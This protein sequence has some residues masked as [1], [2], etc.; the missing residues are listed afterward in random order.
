M[1]QEE[2]QEFK[3]EATDLLNE[4]ENSLLLVEKG[5]DFERHYDSIFRA[6][7]SL[8]GAAGMLELTKLQDH[9]HTIENHF[10][11][12]KGV[13][14]I[15]QALVS[16]FLAA[17]DASRSLLDDKPVNFSYTLPVEDNKAKPS[18]DNVQE[19]PLKAGPS[20]ASSEPNLIF[21]ID[22]EADLVEYIGDILKKYNYPWKGF[23]DPTE[24]LAELEE[25]KPALVLTDMKMPKISG[26]EVL[27]SVKSYNSSLPVIFISGHLTKENLME[28]IALG[29]QGV[30]EKPFRESQ[31]ISLVHLSLKQTQMWRLLNR[32]IDMILF[33]FQD[34]E[35]FL[36]AANKPDILNILKH[37]MEQLLNARRELKKIKKP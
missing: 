28:A 19:T 2:L 14:K 24:A 13:D 18:V 8:K 12:F 35:Q 16:Y 3:I 17:V 23:T 30:I 10:Q 20:K 27:S 34:L 9:L 11:Q 25:L 15:A 22:D 5:E 29:V 36:S 7:H 6:F 37:D 1:E 31:I 4:A 32:S 21:V 26:M 33:Q